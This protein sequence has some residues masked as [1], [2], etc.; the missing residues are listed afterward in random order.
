MTPDTLSALIDATW[1]PAR[2]IPLNDWTI[3]EGASGGSRVSAATG[4]GEIGPAEAAMRDLGQS[5]TFMIRAGEE[6]LDQTLSDQGYRIKDPVTVY[7]CHVAQLTGQR[8]PPVSCFEVQ[9]RLAIQ[10]EIWAAGGIDAARLA[11]MDRA[12]GPKATV[13]GRAGDQ[14]A[15]TLFAAQ[16]GD[17]VMLHA[18]ETL[19]RFRRQ[20]VARRM[21][22]AAAFWAQDQGATTLT[23]L[24]T[25][26]NGGANALYSSLG[27]TAAAGYH[28]RIKDQGT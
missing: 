26:A 19:D 4:S 7:S 25:R 12:P 24:V 15:G 17:T 11:I 8:P 22:T 2:M 14:A 20:G 18:I 23:L 9:G 21:M 1:P 16:S 10:E 3:R 13:L 27:M 28:Y 6:A 5:P